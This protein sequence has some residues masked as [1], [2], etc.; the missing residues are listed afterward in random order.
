MLP[1]YYVN[2]DLIDCF[3]SQLGKTK[4]SLKKKSK[5]GK[6]QKQRKVYPLSYVRVN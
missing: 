4:K 5:V 3:S 6:E 1:Q 2:S